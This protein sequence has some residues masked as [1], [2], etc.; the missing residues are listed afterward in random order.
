MTWRLLHASRHRFGS[1]LLVIKDD[2]RLWW[3]VGYD[4]RHRLHQISYH[5]VSSWTISFSLSR[6]STSRDTCCSVARGCC[7][8][9]STLL[10]TTRLVLQGGLV[11]CSEEWLSFLVGYDDAQ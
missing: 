5:H 7:D 1:R 2:S 4:G 10:S 6:T 11:S 8:S 3:S 9:C